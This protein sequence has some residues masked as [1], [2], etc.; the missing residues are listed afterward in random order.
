MAS[1]A[2]TECLFAGVVVEVPTTGMY[3]EIVA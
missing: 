2:V 1:I 3:E